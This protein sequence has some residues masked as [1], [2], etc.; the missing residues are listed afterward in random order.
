MPINAWRPPNRREFYSLCQSQPSH[1]LRAC[2]ANPTPMLTR[3]RLAVI[4]LILRQREG[5]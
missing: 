3:G 4:R 1:F 5:Q 2:L